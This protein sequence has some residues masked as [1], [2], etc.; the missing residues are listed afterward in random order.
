MAGMFVFM[1]V[2]KATTVHTTI[3][4]TV[5]REATFTDANWDA[6]G[7]MSTMMVRGLLARRLLSYMS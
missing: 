7:E 4:N 1:P 3:Q 2:Q 6:T 5:I